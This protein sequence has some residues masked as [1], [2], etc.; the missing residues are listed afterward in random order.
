[1]NSL[2]T[3]V[4]SR[5]FRR[6]FTE[7]VQASSGNLDLASA[8]L[9]IAGEEYPT[10]A[11]EKYLAYLDSTANVTRRAIP[12]SATATKQLT[13]L[14]THLAKIEGFQGSAEEKPDPRTVYLN[15]VID[16]KLG[17][18]ISLS[19]LYK[20]VAAR[21]GIFLEG[22]GLPGRFILK[23]ANSPEEIFVD[24]AN[25]GAVMSRGD[26]EELVRNMYQGQVV[27]REEFLHPYNDKQILV[28]LLTTLKVCYFESREYAK[29][30]AATD[31]IA[32]IDPTL[33]VNIRE[34]A[35]L[36]YLMGRYRDAI[37]GLELYLK[38]FPDSD[39]EEEI[40]TQIHSLWS[41]VA[42][43]S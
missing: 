24:P 6:L 43:L 36:L 41:L 33:H 3:M 38:I 8:S 18:P 39:D 15:E 40:K 27:F 26:C 17:L 16:R 42:S 7:I 4:D 25:D 11:V 21:N 13:A 23:Y 34:R 22:I 5:V 14:S 20:E 32:I 30:L 12:K 19:I 35:R 31:R 37:R 2:I 28:R 9:Y 1:M 10:L 29:S